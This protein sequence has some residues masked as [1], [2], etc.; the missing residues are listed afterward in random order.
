MLD[1]MFKQTE[2]VAAKHYQ[3]GPDAMRA[4]I[5]EVYASS[6]SIVAAVATLLLLLDGF[7][8]SRSSVT[9]LEFDV[10]RSPPLPPS[11]PCTAASCRA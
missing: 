5:E 7:H 4:L 9:F 3:N 10:Q 11:W 6:K 1:Y 2:K 8:S